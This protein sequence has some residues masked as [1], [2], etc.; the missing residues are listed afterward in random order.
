MAG[1]VFFCVGELLASLGDD[2][3]GILRGELLIVRVAGQGR[4]DGGHFL[5]RDVPGVILA[6]LPALELMVRAR[7]RW[8]VVGRIAREFASFHGGN[9]GDLLQQMAFIG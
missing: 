4:L 5:D 9:G 1:A 7:R 2:H 6:A 8:T 3:I